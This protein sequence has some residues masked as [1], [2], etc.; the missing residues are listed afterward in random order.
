MSGKAFLVDTTKCSGCHACQVSCKQWNNLPGEKTEFFGGPEMTNPAQLSAITF[1][2]VI[3][4]PVDRSNPE[5]PS[6]TIMHK[7]CY[8][9][10]NANCEV[11]C[12][13]KAISKKDE[14]TV[15]DQSRCIGCGACVNEC[16]YKVPHIL[17][18][19]MMKYGIEQPLAKDK[20]YK[21]HACT[22]NKR[23]VPAC[24]TTCPTGALTYGDRVNIVKRAV[25]R[26]EKVKKNYPHA[27]IYGLNEFGGLHVITILKEKPEKYG[28]P[29]DPKPV[30]A[31]K[32][33]QIHDVYGLLAYFT[34][35]IP[36]LKRAAYRISKNLVG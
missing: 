2:H 17:E 21:C 4:F 29:V 33:Q 13:Q 10:Q 22:S 28:L 32:V 20:T 5:K 9:C 8:H 24:A 6:W 1:N 11:V 16:I 15:I 3:F 25:D 19:D 36:S 14:W 18:K 23:D 30:N 26:L 7:K 27:S 12:P 31:A 34:L 35:G